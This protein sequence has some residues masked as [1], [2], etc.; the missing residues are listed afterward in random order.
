M[1]D[2]CEKSKSPYPSGIGVRTSVVLEKHMYLQE[3]KISSDKETYAFNRMDT[4]TKNALDEK[5]IYIL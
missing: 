2:N 1:P 4:W 5:R 3:K